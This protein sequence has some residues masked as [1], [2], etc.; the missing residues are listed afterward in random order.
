MEIGRDGV[1]LHSS[2]ICRAA[3]GWHTVTAHQPRLLSREAGQ[4]VS[5]Q[6]KSC[7][8]RLAV[9]ASAELA[10]Q[11]TRRQIPLVL[12][13]PFAVLSVSLG[14]LELQVVEPQKQS[15][16]VARMAELLRRLH[17]QANFAKRR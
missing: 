12:H 16:C 7:L 11:M 3:D 15:Y 1:T 17:G 8:H 14:A 9:G 5:G 6:V 13:T 4:S 2:E 10:Q